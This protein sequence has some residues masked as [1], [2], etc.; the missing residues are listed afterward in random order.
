L[1]S[2]RD[3]ANFSETV[4]DVVR[5]KSS[6][7][8]LAST[9]RRMRRLLRRNECSAGANPCANGG[10]CV[11]TYRSFFCQCP[12][13]WEGPTCERDVNECAHFAGTDLGCQNGA[14]CQNLPGTYRCHCPPNFYGI[15][16][17]DK[18]NTCSSGSNFET[19]GHG[20]C[21]D[22]RDGVN[23]ICDQVSE[24]ALLDKSKATF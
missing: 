23:C 6:V 19:C 16:C 17:T 10:T 1:Q 14:T 12:P 11:D 15:H 5:L 13:N 21:V 3:N 2:T 7:R 22:T 9:V 4:S 8:R 24:P 20:T 18:A